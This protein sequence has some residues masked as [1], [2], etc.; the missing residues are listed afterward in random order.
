M[1][2]M[3]M[4]PVNFNPEDLL[5][6]ATRR[7]YWIGPVDFLLTFANN[8][9]YTGD[10]VIFI[11]G[12]YIIPSLADLAPLHVQH[13]ILGCPKCFRTRTIEPGLSPVWLVSSEKKKWSPWVYVPSSYVYNQSSAEIR[14]PFWVRALGK[15]TPSQLIR[16]EQPEH[17]PTRVESSDCVRPRVLHRRYVFGLSASTIHARPCL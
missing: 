4:V 13:I 14:S 11:C 3:Q 17:G 5:H 10:V 7:K 6:S 9:W 8:E 2:M 1:V 16:F 12:T 15:H